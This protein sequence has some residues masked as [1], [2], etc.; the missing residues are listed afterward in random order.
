[1]GALDVAAAV[2]VLAGA[3][4]QSAVGFGFALVCAPLLF[5]ALG[6]REAVGLENGLALFVNLVLFAGRRPRP[7]VRTTALVLGWS[8]PGMLAG[9]LVLEQAD[10]R[11]L[12]VALTAMVFVA[13]G[14][15][16]RPARRAGAAPGWVASA[17]GV[18]MGV[19][20]TTISTAGP[21]LVLLVSGRG[22]E[23][24]RVR[25][26]L[27]IVFMAQSVLG[28]AALAATGAGRWPGWGWV[29]VLIPLIGVGQLLGRGLF[30]RLAERGYEKALTATLVV[31][32]TIGL[33]A[34]LL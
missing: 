7:L 24:A 16:L 3:V 31:S 17:T 20:T 26:T 22:H 9:A 5:A 23:P 25:D 4:L 1:M 10:P 18:V 33:L 30:R 32:A 13:L 2:S 27:A 34:A 8:V 28:I 29:A 15:R 21:P 14:L 19:L 11:L 6:P 12:Q